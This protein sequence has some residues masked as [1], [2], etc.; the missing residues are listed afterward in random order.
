M[1]KLTLSI[2]ACTIGFSAISQCQAP[3]INQMYHNNPG[4]NALLYGD[5]LVYG[6]GAINSSNNFLGWTNLK[7]DGNEGHL[8]CFLPINM[9]QPNMHLWLAGDIRMISAISMT[10]NN[11]V[12]VEPGS[13]VEIENIVSNNGGNTIA[14]GLNDSV[15]IY[16]AYYH[17]GDVFPGPNPSNNIPIVSCGGVP[18]GLTDIALWGNSLRW[19]VPEGDVQ[20]QY[21]Q[22]GRDFNSVFFNLPAEGSKVLI[23]SGFYRIKYS[24]SYTEMVR[25]QMNELKSDP[26]IYYVPGKYFQTTKPTGGLFGIKTK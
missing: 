21:S 23:E 24:S 20:I 4:G 10:G 1:K 26:V 3:V 5:L 22:D 15:K 7:I 13:S 11:T 12:T 9:V 18:L 17:V 19:T 6:S 2:L 14:I 8:N 16:N 25:Y